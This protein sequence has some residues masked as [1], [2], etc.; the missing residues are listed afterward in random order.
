MDKFFT[1]RKL[2][3][4]VLA[5]LM[6]SL[7]GCVTQQ[8]E[9]DEPVVENQANRD[10]M[11]ATRIALGLGY[12]RMGNMAQAKANL[13][14]ARLFSPEM[15]QVYTSFA[16][17]YAEVGEHELTISSYEKAISIKDDDPDTL[18]NYGVYLCRNGQLAEAET[19]FLKAIAVPS[20]TLV[21]E[22]YENLASCFLQND[23]FEQAEIYLSKA[24]MHSPNSS[25]VLL[26]L[27]RIEYAM[28]NYKKARA[29]SQK[30]EKVTRRFTS[31]SLALNYKVNMKLR[32]FKTAKNYGT[33]L[34]KMYPQSWESKQ[35]M[36]N[37]LKTIE[38]DTLAEKYR[39]VQAKS[40]KVTP[41]SD[42]KKRVFKLS[43][44]KNRQTVA[45]TKT[46]VEPKTEAQ[47][48]AV[49][50]SDFV[51]QQPVAVAL[52][53]HNVKSSANSAAVATSLITPSTGSAMAKPVNATFTPLKSNEQP[54]L[55]ANTKIH[56]PPVKD[57]S[58]INEIIAEKTPEQLEQEKQLK[59]AQLKKEIES[60]ESMLDEVFLEQD[61]Q[62]ITTSA[63]KK[64]KTHTVAPGETLYKISIKYNVKISTLRKWNG[65]SESSG[66]RS[67]QSLFVSKP[68]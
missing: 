59:A 63:D 66:I 17:Y 50:S 3:K 57:E 13:E 2:S 62:A 32:Q 21:S 36:L 6:L 61:K 11:A 56:M 8:F 51:Q 1:Y 37:G 27:V 31:E 10:E 39:L 44:N 45:N 46:K 49:L 29:Y 26:A 15:V 54:R 4:L 47:K 58:V 53:E 41:A 7:S 43:P 30:F 68:S 5:G 42:P 20:Y 12:L 65:L 52:P 48:E 64:Q 55:A 28:G 23:K 16:H 22:S 14:K 33:M 40:A 67:G 60:K 9:N 19:Q 34:V 35:Y 24:L 38:A 25:S 18:N